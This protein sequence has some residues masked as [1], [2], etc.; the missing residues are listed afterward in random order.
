MPTDASNRV[1]R[2]RQGR[3]VK[4]VSSSDSFLSVVAEQF[5][6]QGAPRS[7]PDRWCGE[8]VSLAQVARYAE[9]SNFAAF[10][11]WSA[12]GLVDVRRKN[13]GLHAHYAAIGGP[14]ESVL[15]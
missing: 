8:R 12:C 15:R 13:A 3:F 2:S 5:R 4:E 7:D 10:G 11:G 14:Y 9:A 6:E 1:S